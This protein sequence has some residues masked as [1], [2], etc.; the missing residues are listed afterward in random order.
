MHGGVKVYRGAPCAA[1]NYV[2]ADRSRA[3]DYYLA[4][5]T[6]IAQCLVVDAEGRV[7]QAGGLDGDR[8]EAWVAGL[9]P[10]TGEPRG[11]LRTDS[12]AV[13]FVEVV[14]NGPKSWSLAAELHPDIA[15]A[16]EAAQA[17]AARQVTGWLGQHA[18]T[19]VGP[20][21]A[22]VAV[23]V[24]RLELAVI[25]HYTSR[26]GD[27]HR[28]LHLQ[29]NARAFAAGKWRGLDTVAI[30]DSIAAINGIGHAAVMCDPRFRDA[31]AMHGYSL[32]SSGEIEQLAD[33][34]GP[35]SQRA[36]Q[37]GAN[38]TRFETEWRTAHPGQEPGLA[39]WRAWDARAWAVQRPD[40]ITPAP[41]EQLHDRWLAELA[42]LG[43]CDPS[44]AVQL[45]LPLPAHLDRDRA[46]DVVLTRL[47]AGRSAWNP[48][49]VRGEA[50]QLLA[51]AGLVADPAARGE[52]AE[53][54]T[55]RALARCVPLTGAGVPAHTRALTSRRVLD[56]E[57]DLMARL[58][59]RGAEPV[60][61]ADLLAPLLAADDLDEG[62]CTAVA[63]LTS[64]AP[65][66]VVEGAAGVGKTA[67]LAAARAELDAVGERL[68]VVTPTLKAAQAASRQVGARAGSVAWL[69]YQ[70]GWRW[71]EHGSWTR[72]TIGEIDPRGGKIYPGPREDALLSAGDMLVVDEAGMLDQDTGLALLTVA[73]D[74]GVRVALIGDR[75]QLPA[76]GRGGVLEHAHRFADPTALVHLDRVHRFTRTTLTPDGATVTVPDL[77]YAALSLQMRA[78][79]DPGAVF[80]QLSQRGQVTLHASEAERHATLAELVTA[81]HLAGGDVAVVVDTREQAAALNAAI[82]DRMVAAGLV[83]DTKTATG[84]DGQRVSVGDTVATR[85]NDHA[86][87]VANRDLW[88]VTGVHPDGSLTVHRVRTGAR[89]D[90]HNRWGDTRDRWGD[91]G[92]TLPRE[93]VREHVELGYVVTV[94]GAQGGTASTA[95]LLLGE[96]TSAASAYVGM[97]RGRHANT[98]HLVADSDADAG[99]LWQAAFA[100]DRAD[101]G[102]QHAG[103]ALAS[104]T[105]GYTAERQRP[106][107]ARLN[108]VLDQLRAAWREQLIAQTQLQNLQ[109][110]LDQATA[111][112]AWWQHCQDVLSP[113][114]RARETARLAAERAGQAA[115]GCAERLIASTNHH[116]AQ[117]RHAWDSDLARAA[118]AA[119]TI[120]AGPGRLGLHRA[121]IYQAE[122]DLDRWSN[123]WRHVLTGAALDPDTLTRWPAQHPS[124]APDIHAALDQH[125]RRQAATEHPDDASRLDRAGQAREHHDAASAALHQARSE[126][127]RRSHRPLYDTGAADQIPDLTSQV[128]VA[129]HRVQQADRH[130]ERLDRDPAITSHPDHP[131][132]LAT[133][134]TAWLEDDIAASR[135]T[136]A[137][138]HKPIHS[139]RPEPYQHIRPD[140]HRGISR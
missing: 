54:L 58:A 49:D 33:Y 114:E 61:P 84:R 125:A 69:V 23:P 113:L 72:L 18:T 122:A 133:A 134:Q 9:D 86:L 31:L 109:H 94:H 108:A 129:E 46:A 76:I 3:D 56:V 12:A 40:K 81:E 59:A 136:T 39:R 74:H 26:A 126:L 1:R 90:T 52:L 135:R 121:R 98:A 107:P 115:A 92:V 91:I 62:Q 47:G 68:L 21:G 100:R 119:A 22:Q 5:G 111:E 120:T 13:R 63:A 132:L 51:R 6:G 66:V 38:I 60:D 14:V 17:S 105:A 102:P 140:H 124:T 116:L 87:G 43:Y 83:D 75:Y 8:Y 34:V 70:H 28:H 11:R 138:A 67:M 55:A 127:Q 30:R 44:R 36:A 37:I 118:T 112:A 45:A 57:A 117:L 71:D 48:A 95:H 106:D 97:T 73:D 19:R 77:D 103:H 32:N 130:A 41:G 35:F 65:L 20:R 2:E 104:A 96:H 42:R 25:R 139:I 89:G 10:A 123:A 50:E 131:T 101:L 93:Y 80:D 128:S 137:H 53:D 88:T 110:R 24:Q 64:G 29:I 27:P 7:V 16:Y 79:D 82:R 4:E 78:G 85:R 99:E 15:Q